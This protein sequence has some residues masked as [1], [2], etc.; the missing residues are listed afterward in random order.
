MSDSITPLVQKGDSFQLASQKG[1]IISQKGDIFHRK[2]HE[3]KNSDMKPS[4][5]SD[6]DGN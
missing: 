5:G 6:H 4:I 3:M 1:D 2:D